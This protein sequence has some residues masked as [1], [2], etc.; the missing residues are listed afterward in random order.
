MNAPSLADACALLEFFANSGAI[1]TEAGIA[2]MQGEV[3]VSPIT[4]WELT[5]KAALGKLPPLPTAN[6]SFA[7]W[8]ASQGF[9]FQQ[10]TWA[11]T[12]RANALPPLHK[13]PMDRMLIAQ[14]LNAG[15]VVITQDAIYARYGVPTVW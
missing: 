6:G 14:A 13:D 12:E 9:R 15:T 4:V 8:L 11:D 5:R 1:M 7:G 3:A 2:A 10:L